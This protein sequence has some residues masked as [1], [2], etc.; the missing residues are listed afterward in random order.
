MQHTQ[1]SHT[2][3]EI[4]L[5]PKVGIP[6]I[7]IIL[8]DLV[9]CIFVEQDQLLGNIQ[10]SNSIVNASFL[11]PVDKPFRSLARNTADIAAAVHGK[12]PRIICHSCLE[13]PDITDA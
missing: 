6:R 13:S 7:L 8:G 9:A 5:I 11:V 10:R 12:Q 1:F 3:G 2:A 4:F